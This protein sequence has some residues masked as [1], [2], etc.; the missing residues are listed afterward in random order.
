MYPYTRQLHLGVVPIISRVPGHSDL[1]LDGVNGFTFCSNSDLREIL[2]KSSILNDRSYFKLASSS[3]MM[4]MRLAK[5]SKLETKKHFSQ[6][7]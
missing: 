5:Y 7:I 3:K 6:Y 2:F 4:S 1:V